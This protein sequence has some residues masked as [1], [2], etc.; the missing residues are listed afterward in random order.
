MVYLLTFGSIVR[1]GR[2]WIDLSIFRFQPAEFV[3]IIIILGM[4]RL[5]YL[6]RGQINSWKTILWSFFYAL[7][8]AV[9]IVLEPDLGSAILIMCLC[10]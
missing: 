4:A 7:L 8:P 10:K 5:L 9:L 3:K 6:K 1:G 2:R